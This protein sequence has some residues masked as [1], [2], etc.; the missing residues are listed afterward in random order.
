MK[1]L[2]AGFQAGAAALVLAALMAAIPSDD[3]RA[4]GPRVTINPPGSPD[5]LPQRGKLRSWERWRRLLVL[6]GSRLV[7]PLA[8]S[9]E[10]WS[11]LGWTQSLMSL[12]A[13]FRNLTQ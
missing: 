3:V 9:R 12:Y 10:G 2:D 13:H 5:K 6:V 7:K 4:Q 1:K 8:H 11:K